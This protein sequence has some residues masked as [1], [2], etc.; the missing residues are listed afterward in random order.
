LSLIVSTVRKS[1]ARIP[2]ACDL[3]ELGSTLG[4]PDGEQGLRPAR[5]R[6]VRTVVA[7]ILISSF[8]SFPRIRWYPQRGF[9][10]PRRTTRSR[11]S[12]SIGGRPG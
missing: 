7:E 4:R 3:Q 12:G 1:V 6:I 11:T 5:S 10:L 9:S 2:A 8:M